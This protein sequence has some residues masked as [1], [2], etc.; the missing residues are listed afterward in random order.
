MSAT[1]PTAPSGGSTASTAARIVS[2]PV[3]SSAIVRQPLASRSAIDSGLR[4][5]AYTVCP[6]AAS[7]SAVARPIP[8]EQPVI[9][10]A[11]ETPAIGGG[12]YPAGPPGVQHQPATRG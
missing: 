3:T 9:R 1:A 4:A 6:P 11:F 10:T 7:R 2:S 5:V 8:V 12:L